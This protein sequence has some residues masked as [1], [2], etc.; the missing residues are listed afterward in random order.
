VIGGGG[1]AGLLSVATLYLVAQIP[2]FAYRNPG[3]EL[4]PGRLNAMLFGTATR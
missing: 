1:L 3:R 2:F 4:G